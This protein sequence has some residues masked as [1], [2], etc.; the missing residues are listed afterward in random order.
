[1]RFGL[2]LAAISLAVAAPSPSSG[3]GTTAE[4]VDLVKR[5]FPYFGAFPRRLPYPGNNAPIQ[6]WIPWILQNFPNQQGYIAIQKL[7][8]VAARGGKFEIHITQTPRP[9][10][11]PIVPQPPPPVED[12]F[13]PLPQEDSEGEGIV[14]G[15]DSA[16]RPT[17][18]LPTGSVEA[19]YMDYTLRLH[20]MVRPPYGADTPLVWSN[21]MAAKAQQL[22]SG[23]EYRHSM[24]K[25]EPGQRRGQN[26]A[27]QT[28]L[29]D[30]MAAMHRSFHDWFYVEE[31]YYNYTDGSMLSDVPVPLR[32]EGQ[33][34]ESVGH[35]EIIVNNAFD[36]IGCITQ[37]C[38]SL[39]LKR[40]GAT[41]RSIV[42]TLPD[43]RFTVCDFLGS[44]TT[45]V[46]L[47]IRP[48]FG[49][50]PLDAVVY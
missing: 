18:E 41:G 32:Y 1:M 16:R 23:C 48:P 35:F 3:N 42:D 34:A 9:H 11:A 36:Q 50:P 17:Y 14:D 12:Q 27:F 47:P 6:Q 25:P 24:L 43:G 15:D 5:Q 44:T 46:R 7:Q 4:V 29:P 19:R 30:D 10:A 2:F 8:A 33:V 21:E 45:L 28:G 22:A 26:I 31:R 38:P 39:K 13:E 49:S 37:Y 20:N 40:V